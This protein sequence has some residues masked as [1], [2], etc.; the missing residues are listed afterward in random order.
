MVRNA[1][2]HYYCTNILHYP[3]FTNAMK[4]HVVNNETVRVTDFHESILPIECDI[5]LKFVFSLIRSLIF[6]V[7]DI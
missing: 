7:L 4:K 2:S 3:K 1:L 5:N 6:N